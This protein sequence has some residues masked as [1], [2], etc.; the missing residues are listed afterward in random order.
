MCLR[1]C[2]H[3]SHEYKCLLPPFAMSASFVFRQAGHDGQGRRNKARMV[4][5]CSSRSA[6]SH[7]LKCDK[8]RNRVLQLR[9][10]HGL[11]AA[12]YCII[13]NPNILQ[14]LYKC[15]G[16]CVAINQK[17]VYLNSLC[18]GQWSPVIQ[19]I[20]IRSAASVV[21]IMDVLSECVVMLL[22]VLIYFRQRRLCKKEW[23]RC[24]L[25]LSNTVFL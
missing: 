15:V 3:A 25:T 7:P 6:A 11:M 10:G 2:R 14:P 17:D 21:K 22:F 12:K 24:P 19:N 13:Y 16:G 9:V 23:R 4:P 5:H 8:R 18:F 1:L 20:S